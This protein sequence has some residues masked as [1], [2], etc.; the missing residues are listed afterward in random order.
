MLFKEPNM[1]ISGCI[2]TISLDHALSTS[3]SRAS[4][5]EG[6][7]RAFLGEDCSEEGPI[8]GSSGT[9]CRGSGVT[10]RCISNSAD[11]M[12]GSERDARLTA[13]IAL[14]SNVEQPSVIYNY[15]RVGNQ[16]RRAFDQKLFNAGE[17]V[18]KQRKV[19][20]MTV[21]TCDNT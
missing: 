1:E 9:D 13:P 4:Y 8:D 7:L 12:H 16:R 20:M 18:H 11:G 19:G 3:R 2:S 15:T 10:P 14:T 5:H 17:V 6:S 21:D